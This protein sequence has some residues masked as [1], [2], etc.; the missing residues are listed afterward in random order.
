MRAWRAYAETV[1][2]LTTALERDLEPTGLSLGE[3]QVL[4][5]LSESP[6]QQLRMTELATRLQ[7]TPSGLTRRLDGL[8]RRHWVDRSPCPIDGR[9]TYAVLTPAGQRV[10]EAAA[11]LHVESVR[12]HIFDHLTPAQA[13]SLG[14]VFSAIARGLHAAP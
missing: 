4:V 11:P 3:Y 9:V 13:R 1:G 8:V 6:D 12:T 2:D 10:L 7:V 14:D 5:F